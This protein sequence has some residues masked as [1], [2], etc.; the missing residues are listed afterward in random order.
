MV[1]IGVA[2]C[3]LCVIPQAALVCSKP[4]LCPLIH[5]SGVPHHQPL[6]VL[7]AQSV[8]GLAHFGDGAA[9][10]DPRP[11]VRQHDLFL[12]ASIL[13]FFHENKNRPFCKE[14]IR[15]LLLLRVGWGTI[16]LPRR[17]VPCPAHC[18]PLLCVEAF[19]PNER[20][21]RKRLFIVQNN[22]QRLGFQTCKDR[23]PFSSFPR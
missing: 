12:I 7:V 16:S 1:V 13:S 21:H 10:D 5:G 3:V 14:K 17:C 22:C 8:G 11:A 20:P 23:L 6:P 4:R 2:V 19:D 18:L 9:I 15:S